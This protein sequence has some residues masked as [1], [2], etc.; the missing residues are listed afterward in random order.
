MLV[1]KQLPMGIRGLYS[2]LFWTAAN[3]IKK[4]SLADW[5]GKKIGV[6]ILCL[7]YRSRSLGI[8]LLWNLSHFLAACRAQQIQ[9]VV[10]FDGSPHLKNRKL[11]HS[12]E[13]YGKT[14]I[15]SVML[16]KQL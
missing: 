1:H 7:L 3:T 5:A 14:L 16:L 11:W 15:N 2:F 8:P 13:N 12:G 9:L 6:D 4:Q 10:V